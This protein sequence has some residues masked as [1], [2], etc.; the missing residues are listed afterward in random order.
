M[1]EA[2]QSR[3]KAIVPMFVAVIAYVSATFGWIPP[4]FLTEANL[5][6]AVA[7]IGPV[8]AYFWSNDPETVL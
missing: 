7:F 4:E 6:K 5:Y 3:M 2:I 1:K 8:I